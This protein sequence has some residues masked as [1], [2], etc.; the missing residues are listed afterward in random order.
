MLVFN[1]SNLNQIII[2]KN[3]KVF[4][5]NS[6]MSKYL[7]QIHFIWFDDLN[8]LF[9]SKLRQ[10]YQPR[11]WFCLK[12]WSNWLLIDF[13]DPNSWNPN[14]LSQQNW[15]NHVQT[16]WKKSI[17]IKRDQIYM[18][19]DRKKFKKVKIYWLFWLNFTFS[20]F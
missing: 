13:F 3:L 12:S 10:S 15:L 5:I 6:S 14:Q 4:S 18:K 9:F 2:W 17:Y 8:S 1:F 20:I 7:F 16:I 11:L 19:N